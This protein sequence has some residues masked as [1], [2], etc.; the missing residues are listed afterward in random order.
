MTTIVGIFDNVRD[1]DQAVRRLARAGFED[2]VYDEAIIAGETRE[3]GLVLRLAT[4]RQRFG[5]HAE[6]NLSRKPDLHTIV[7]AFRAHLAEYRLPKEVIKAYATTFVHN[8]E[9]ISLEPIPSMPSKSW[10]SCESAAPP[11]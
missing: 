6:P 3:I 4:L 10:R 2:T 1:L 5:Q 7:R 11:G 8:G 9:F